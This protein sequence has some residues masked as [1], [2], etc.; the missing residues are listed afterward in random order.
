MWNPWPSTRA[1]RRHRPG[2]VRPAAAIV[3]ELVAGAAE[4]LTNPGLA[5]LNRDRGVA[6][7]GPQGEATPQPAARRAGR[8]INRSSR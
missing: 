1:K 8:A 2:H 4:A 7:R 3:D 5:A 6:G